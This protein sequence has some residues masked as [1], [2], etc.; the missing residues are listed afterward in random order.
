MGLVNQIPKN[1]DKRSTTYQS[2]DKDDGAVGGEEEK[3][4]RR[5]HYEMMKSKTK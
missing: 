5:Y 1:P 4:R 2:L 3:W